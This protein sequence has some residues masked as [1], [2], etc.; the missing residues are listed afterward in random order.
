MAKLDIYKPGWIDVVFTGRNK[1]Y[2]A[3]ELRR[4]NPKT[5]SRA[6]LIGGLFFI[7][8]I[9]GTTIY[10]YVAGIVPNMKD[11]FKQTE[12]KLAAPPPIE[13]KP[14]PPP[15]PPPHHLVQ[16]H[17]TILHHSIKQT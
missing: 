5:T 15:P 17:L 6:L 13:N 1:A 12:I 16:T 10:K 11:M 4:D 2:G 8:S 9:S 7:L 14:P 3:Y